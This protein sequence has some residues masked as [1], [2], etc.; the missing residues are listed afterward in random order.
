MDG[1]LVHG[2]AHAVMRGRGFQ[3]SLTLPS[4][5]IKLAVVIWILGQRPDAHQLVVHQNIVVDG[6]FAPS[7]HADAGT[8]GIMVAENRV[9]FRKAAEDSSR[10]QLSLSIENLD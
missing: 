5:A 10:H 2:C 9:G 3:K 7:L 1:H 6:E 4:N 8:R